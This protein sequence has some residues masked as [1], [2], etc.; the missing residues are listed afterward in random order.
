MKAVASVVLEPQDIQQAIQDHISKV[1][2]VTA[3]IGVTV[4]ESSDQY[5]ITVLSAEFSRTPHVGAKTANT[6]GKRRGRRTNAVI[7]AEKAA[8]AAGD[9]TTNTVT[10]APE[11]A[12][13][14]ILDS[15]Y[16]EPI[17]VEAEVELEVQAGVEQSAQ[18]AETEVEFG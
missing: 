14:S 9:A 18:V 5:T 17:A 13:T 6:T 11:Q 2:N 12:D 15:L 10:A 4:G 1:L 8:K 16:A 7:E 3:E